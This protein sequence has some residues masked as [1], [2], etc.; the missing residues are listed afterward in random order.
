MLPSVS[1][2]AGSATFAGLVPLSRN[3]RGVDMT[4]IFIRYLLLLQNKS[5]TVAATPRDKF[6]WLHMMKSCGTLIDLV[7]FINLRLRAI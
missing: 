1:P 6:A 3:A 5:C 7:L 2:R 4:G